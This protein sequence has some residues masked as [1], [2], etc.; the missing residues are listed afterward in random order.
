MLMWKKLWNDECGAI[1][2][3][4]LVII[5][6]ILVIGMITG[7]TAVRDA[8]VS[9]LADVGQAISQLNQ[10][11]LFGGVSGHGTSTSGSSFTD[12][13]DF[14]DGASCVNPSS[15]SRCTTFTGTAT[16]EGSI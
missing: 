8:V 4:E 6:T 7:L 11:Y 13:T 9:E 3:A 2:S 16:P 1:L 14:C 15:P 12:H 5:A 10:S